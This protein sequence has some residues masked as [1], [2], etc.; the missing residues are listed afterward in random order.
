MPRTTG[1]S[2]THTWCNDPNME[3]EWHE[4]YDRVHL[5]D[6][7]ATGAA[8]TATRWEV[9]HPPAIGPR[10]ITIYEVSAEDV[11]GA[12]AKASAASAQWR[13]AGRMHPSHCIAQADVVRALG[14]W[15]QKPPPSPR[16]K[17]QLLVYTMCNEPGQEQSFNG[18]YDNVHIPDVLETGCF[19]AATRWVRLQ[20]QAVGANHL[21]IYEIEHDDIEAAVARSGE[22]YPR[23]KARGRLHPNLAITQ[24]ALV[25]PVG[26]RV[27]AAPAR[28]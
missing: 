1:L 16:T 23:L 3:R 14:R 28:G 9:L 5:P 2:I 24:S 4:W 11:A 6:V 21:A 25:R 20:P 8:W 10:F 27:G 7:L 13:A 17:G 12:V 15:T 18:W 22:N 26:A 19:F